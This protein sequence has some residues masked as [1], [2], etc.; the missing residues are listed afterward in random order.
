MRDKS[1][2]LTPIR[3]CKTRDEMSYLIVITGAAG[4][5]SVYW[6]QTRH[7]QANTV[8]AASATAVNV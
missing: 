4:K 7:L 6:P 5:Q 3:A 1:F 2:D 8:P